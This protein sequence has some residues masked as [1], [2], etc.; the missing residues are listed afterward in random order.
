MACASILCSGEPSVSPLC[1]GG[2]LGL[3]TVM[4][5]GRLCD[6]MVLPLCYRL[7]L[8]V[9]AP[10]RCPFPTRH[11]LTPHTL[12]D[13]SGEPALQ[14]GRVQILLKAWR[15]KSWASHQTRKTKCFSFLF[16]KVQRLFSVEETPSVFLGWGAAPPSPSQPV[17][18]P[19][20]CGSS[21]PSCPR[22]S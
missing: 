5:K 7:P 16:L 4:L 10:R 19:G 21:F 17:V 9:A 20:L 15:K 14:A 6:P 22:A 18:L 2:L 8:H 13:F 12:F 11:P 1:L 3:G